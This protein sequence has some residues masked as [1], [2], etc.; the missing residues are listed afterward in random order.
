MAFGTEGREII[1]SIEVPSTGGGIPPMMD[2]Q[3]FRG[4][5]QATAM[6]VALQC[7]R[8]KPPP[9]RR[10]YVILVAFPTQQCRTEPRH[11]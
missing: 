10:R 6:P 5:T 2:F 11:A 1:D 8:T 9:L 7:F 4:V 3:T